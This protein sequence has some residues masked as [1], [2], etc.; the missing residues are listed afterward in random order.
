MIGCGIV[1]WLL[2][3]QRLGLAILI[4]LLRKR[5]EGKMENIGGGEEPTA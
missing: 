1:I 4:G 2:I 3:S 5:R